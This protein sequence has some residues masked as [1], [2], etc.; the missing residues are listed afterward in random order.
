ML[1][2]M[3]ILLIVSITNGCAGRQ[4]DD[5]R[6]AGVY[7]SPP[8]DPNDMRFWSYGKKAAFKRMMEK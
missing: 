5:H 3:M 6:P 4:D 1:K 2:L 8:P 7:V